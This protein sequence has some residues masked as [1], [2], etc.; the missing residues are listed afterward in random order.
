MPLLHCNLVYEFDF[1]QRYNDVGGI[2]NEKDIA[3]E[4]RNVSE[5]TKLFPQWEHQCGLK[6]LFT[7]IK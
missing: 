2:S 7:S 5:I 3:I 1:E 4:G 6:Y